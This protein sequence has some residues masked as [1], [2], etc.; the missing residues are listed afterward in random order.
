[1]TVTSELIESLRANYRKPEKL[2]GENGLLKL[3][4]QNIWA[5][6]RMTV[7][8]TLRAS[9]A[10]TKNNKTLKG[11]FG[12]FSIEIPNNRH[13][14]L[15]TKIVTKHQTHWSGFDEKILPLYAQA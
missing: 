13:G 1:M 11:D 4:W 12:E 10:T 2:I 15:E 9:P 3:W 8:P 14:T 7:L 6:P 5:T